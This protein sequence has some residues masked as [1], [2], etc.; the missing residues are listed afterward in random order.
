M[1][2]FKEVIEI[3]EDLQYWDTCPQ[4]YKDKIP[5]LVESLSL[6]VLS[7]CIVIQQEDSTHGKFTMQVC[8]NCKSGPI[9]KYENFC[10]KCGNK[11]GKYCR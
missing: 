4:E 8:G 7:D 9:T 1:A 10:P 2:D 5:K 11:I 3:L 6:P